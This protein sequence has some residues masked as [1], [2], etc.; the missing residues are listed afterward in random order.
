EARA[1]LKRAKKSSQF[2]LP[3][4]PLLYNIAIMLVLGRCCCCCCCCYCG[5]IKVSFR[6]LVP[7]HFSIYLKQVASSKRQ[8]QW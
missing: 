6:R 4:L 7:A 8:R 3:S 5:A 2:E 1:M